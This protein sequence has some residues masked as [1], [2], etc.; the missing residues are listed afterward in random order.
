MITALKKCPNSCEIR[1]W[2]REYVN[3][4]KTHMK[5]KIIYVI[6]NTNAKKH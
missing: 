6:E 4:Y 1:K 2:I 3:S 5:R